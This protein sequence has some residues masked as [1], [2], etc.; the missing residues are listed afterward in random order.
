MRSV[1]SFKLIAA[2]LL[3]FL[4]GGA[5]SYGLQFSKKSLHNFI[6]SQ[7][8]LNSPA[9]LYPEQID[10][11]FIPLGVSFKN[12]SITPRGS[13]KNHIA[14]S[15]AKSI[16][17]S[18]NPFYLALG[19]LKISHLKIV[20]LNASYQHTS[21]IK[22][23]G[24]NDTNLWIQELLKL[25]LQKL[26]LQKLNLYL[27]DST[28]NKLS[29]KNIE[30]S[31]KNN[32][33]IL[34]SSISIENLDAFTEKANVSNLI[35][36]SKFTLSPEKIKIN[37]FS[38][39]KNN[40][41]IELKGSIDGNINKFSYQKAA[42]NLRTSLD[43]TDFKDLAA[44]IV[45][46][47]NVEGQVK[48]EIQLSKKNMGPYTYNGFLNTNS[49]SVD[50][51]HIGEMKSEFK[52]IDEKLI[53]KS[54]DLKAPGAKLLLSNA[55]LNL[56]NN[57]A[58]KTKINIKDFEL[59]H[60]LKNLNIRG[61]PLHM[62]SIAT[63]NCSGYLLKT[64]IDCEG[65][66]L[67]DHLDVVF[68]EPNTESLFHSY[69]IKN[70]FKLNLN[71][72]GVN[73][74]TKLEMADALANVSG[75]IDFKRGYD[76]NF[77]TDV[78]SLE[79]A[80]IDLAK[81]K[82]KGTLKGKGTFKG[83]TRR[84]QL[85][86]NAFSKDFMLDGFFLGNSGY[87]LSYDKNILDLKNIKTKLRD[88]K[89]DSQVSI[90][91]NS[92]TIKLQS[93][94]KKTQAQDIFYSFSNHLKLPVKVS[95]YGNFNIELD[96]PIKLNKLN[97]KFSGRFNNLFVGEENFDT[98]DLKTTSSN[99]NLSSQEIVL[100]KA[101]S[102]IT[103]TI[104]LKRTGLINASFSGTP[105]ELQSLDVLNNRNYKFDGLMEPLL[106]VSNYINDPEYNISLK[107][108]DLYYDN[109][110][111]NSTFINFKY[112]N[113]Y[114]S[115]E[116]QF[117]GSNKITWDVPFTNTRPSSLSATFNKFNFAYLLKIILG[118][119]DLSE[120]QSVLSA[121]IN[122]KSNSDY[123]WKSNGFLNLN[124]LTFGNSDQLIKANT[125]YNIPIQSGVISNQSID[126]SDNRNLLKFKL[127]KVSKNNLDIKS[128]SNL[129]LSI[130]QIIFPFVQNL[131]GNLISF[132]DIRGSYKKPKVTG[133]SSVKNGYFSF[134]D[135][136][137][138]VS[139]L[140][141]EIK[142]KDDR[143]YITSLKSNFGGGSV[144]GSGQVKLDLPLI[145]ININLKGQGLSLEIP[146]GMTT[147][148]KGS[149]SI[150]GNQSPYLFSGSYEV[151]GG[152]YIYNFDTIEETQEVILANKYLPQ[153]VKK[154]KRASMILDYN[155]KTKKP[156]KSNLIVNGSQ[157][158]VSMEGQL[159][160][161][162]ELEKLKATGSLKSSSTGELIFRENNFDILSANIIYENQDITD[163][164]F[165]IKTQTV[166]SPKVQDDEI[167]QNYNISMDILGTAQNPT[168]NFSSQPILTEEDILS[169]LAVGVTS[170]N[171]DEDVDSGKQALKTSYEVGTDYIKSK[172]GI[173]KAL[174]KRT[175][176][177]VNVSSTI[178]IED[179]NAAATKFNIK[180]Q[181]SD[182]FEVSASQTEGSNKANDMELRYKINKQI[183]LSSQWE[184]QQENSATN[185]EDTI[186]VGIEYQIEFD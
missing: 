89:F 166:V 79:N 179:E 125:I 141:S 105:V 109:Q 162:G 132:F 129:D 90:D 29:F 30:A 115:G 133:N 97:H 124:E 58:I 94:S 83:D 10:Y 142:I 33:S 28:N 48:S 168:L 163:P 73:I 82:M 170:Q 87:D 118:A 150:T 136:P 156:V 26:T 20:G 99:G 19:K 175:G 3:F 35:L 157:T 55:E 77:D 17:I 42:L 63:L 38:T 71:R 6:L 151:D 1:F 108:K 127:N 161:H 167:G 9:T 138:A 182:N 69:D 171:L 54:I 169:L 148:G 147:Q 36:K 21:N 15:S 101:N 12:I 39:L 44:D 123:L 57:I 158:T 88:S 40:S 52:G 110:I 139:S 128:E 134:E 140:D 137:H 165:N 75:F 5:I 98:L 114:T 160:V 154:K 152:D 46:F 80:F 34:T 23:A 59:Q 155:I 18:I 93:K 49:I 45:S 86:V 96:G 172:L 67:T 174:K 159:K 14:L 37:Q 117:L 65:Q 76:L 84:G 106:I 72:K 104:D 135:L 178:D 11:S 27:S 31:I 25:P 149:L 153:F 8:Q 56:K 184:R 43:L 70:L 51:F 122:L 61:V 66:S 78:S 64:N 185:E 111:Y 102:T 13:I 145:P 183:S 41:F 7:S 144:I 120:Y 81:L 95:G 126:L 116:S 60:Y 2:Y 100:K 53:F 130:L 62:R 131:K 177:E 85:K 112:S 22:S 16:K 24:R 91:L 103:G 4:L 113:I 121:D 146:E 186:G 68:R 173:T 32:G 164:E 50:Q 119:T 181:F 107:F 180:K 92:N 47:S 143:F 74:E 176:L